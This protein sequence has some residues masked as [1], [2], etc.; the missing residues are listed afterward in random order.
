[1]AQVTTFDERP[2]A[3][4]GRLAAEPCR[5]A[6]PETLAALRRAVRDSGRGGVLSRGLGRSYGDAAVNGGGA[7]LLHERL[8]RFLAFDA[9]RG[10]LECEA[11]VSL[12]SILDVFLPRGWFLPVTPGTKFVTVG[13]AI[14]ADVHGKNHHVE[15]TFGRHVESLRLLLASGETILCSRDENAGAFHATVGGMGLTGA[16][17]SARFRLLKI[18]TSAIRLETRRAHS[19]DAALE[20]FE[21]GD[22]EWRYSVAWIDGLARG[23]SLG[24]SVLLRGDH[25]RLEEL[26][27]A[28]RE[29]PLALAKPFPLAV[30]FDLP[31]FALSGPT[32]RA[33]NAGIWTV[34]RDGSSLVSYEPF[35]YPLDSIRDW[36]RMYGRRGFVQYQALLPRERS[37]AGLVALLEVLAASGLPSFLAVLKSTGEAGEGLLSFPFAGHTLALDLPARRGVADLARRLD[38]ILLRHGGRLYLAKDALTSREAFAEMYPSRARFL[39]EKRRLDP[40]GTFTSTMARRVG[41]SDAREAREG[42]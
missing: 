8:A 16:I 34:K 6:R 25:A 9:D 19:L 29:S 36:N 38:A 12:A 10:V 13:G 17:V 35:F 27:K 14:A 18:E 20:A 39:D 42:R 41:L 7:V 3:G 4:W 1:M 11:G 37:R 32:V 30:P 5:V 23:R 31:A 28:R 40:S 26:P 22:R 21:A 24:R 15:G 2:L 33:F